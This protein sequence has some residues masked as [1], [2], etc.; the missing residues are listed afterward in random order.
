MREALGRVKAA[1]GDQAV[2]V[3]T[4][5]VK[6]GLLGSAYEIAAAIDDDRV[7]P[8]PRARPA[9]LPP[10]PAAEAELERAVAPLRA[11]LRSLRAMVRARSEER[12][13]GDVR[14]ELAALR[15]A[16]DELRTHAPAP[17]V[18]PPAPF[19]PAV[20]PDGA[21]VLLVGP[22][23]VGKTT[24]IAKIAAQA[25]LVDRRRVALVTLDNYRV[26]G[27]DQIRIF[28]DLIGVPLHV[29]DDPSQ[30]ALQLEE[31]AAYELVLIDSAGR[32]P[33]DAGALAALERG[34]VAA[35][36]VQVHLVVAA[37]STAAQI[38]ELQRRF[39]GA[40]PRRL[41]FTKLDEC[42]RAPELVAAP[43]RLQLPVTWLATGQAVPEDLEV[44]TAPRLVEL[45]R[46]GLYPT[47]N[48]DVAA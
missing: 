16:V 19:T 12:P 17:R 44:A 3:S 18:T 31:L 28:A 9:A 45:A 4:R 27:V 24:T 11:E 38:D 1:L 21:V 35:P 23:G 25:A 15:R 36:Q 29:L 43:E 8:G 40:R 42:E 6:R 46:R 32:S 14:G 26:G 5:Q 37:G 33:R 48:R 2:V 13:G 20:A 7:E 34:L 39:A 10:R 47:S 30:L 22:T 41:L